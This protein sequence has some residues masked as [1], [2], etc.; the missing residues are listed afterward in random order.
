[1][2]LLALS[3]L[4]TDITGANPDSRRDRDQGAADSHRDQRPQLTAGDRR[5]RRAPA[6]H[7]ARQ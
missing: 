4:H 7:A 5:G 3:D 6:G 1:M 2:K